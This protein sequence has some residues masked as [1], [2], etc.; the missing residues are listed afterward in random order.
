MNAA[1]AAAGPMA[2][3]TQ[4]QAAVDAFGQS[5]QQLRPDQLEPALFE[6]QQAL[7]SLNHYSGGFE[8]LSRDID[9]LPAAQRE[10]ARALLEQA[11]SGHRLNSELLQLAM[12]RNAAMQS[13]VAQESASATYSPDGGVQSGLGG[14]LLGKY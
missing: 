6:M 2:V 11:R 13:Y 3:L 10:Q 4:L 9:G 5:L 1:G 14:Q 8:G 12:Q 7:D